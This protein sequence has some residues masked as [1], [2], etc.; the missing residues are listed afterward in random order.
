VGGEG[1]RGN[2]NLDLILD[3]EETKEKGVS[4]GFCSLEK[5]SRKLDCLG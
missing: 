1:W 4:S 2:P 3:G 5:K